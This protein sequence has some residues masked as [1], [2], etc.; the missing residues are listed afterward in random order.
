VSEHLEPAQLMIVLEASASAGE[1]LQAALAAAAVAS[2][3]I[4]GQTG[5][6][7]DAATAASLVATAQ[8][9]GAAVLIADDAPLART[10]KADG[11]HVGVGEGLIGRAREA[12]EIVGARAIVGVDAGRSRDDAMV[13]GDE[14]GDYVGFGIPAFVKERET[15][16]DRRLDLIEWWADIFSV[17]CVAFDV[18]D[19]EEARALAAA[20]A[21][22][23]SI[24]I[25]G[26]MS[27]SETR[28]RVRDFGTAIAEGS[29]ARAEAV[30]SADKAPK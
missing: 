7:L 26:G 29:A 10:L 5:R 17:P 8:K 12:R 2:V 20:G 13:A 9:L 11:V 16:I 28:D 21:D 4:E 24:R 19:V 22:F 14:V 23:V 25:E 15:A 6:A 1:R 18:S 30:A 27:V 3:V